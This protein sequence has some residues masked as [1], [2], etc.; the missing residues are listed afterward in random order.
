MNDNPAAKKQQT[1][2]SREA[3]G[4][5]PDRV[6]LEVAINALE[7]AG[8]D[9]E[10]ISVLG[11]DAEVRR[12][13]GLYRSVAEIEDDA[14]VPR[15]PFVSRYERVAGETAAVAF[16]LYI[17]GIAGLAAVIASGG[18]LALAIAA[19]IVGSAA[20]A[21]LGGFLAGAIAEHHAKHIQRQIEQGGLVLW[22]KVGDNDAEQRAIAVLEQSGASD[23]HAHQIT[24]RWAVEE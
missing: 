20:G 18:A 24:R 9:P 15:A 4:V 19:A 6:A 16:P 10:A 21:S 11:P 13:V 14:R 1:F 8:F 12:R 5:F 3:V 2:A 22:V 17:G 23:V 7:E